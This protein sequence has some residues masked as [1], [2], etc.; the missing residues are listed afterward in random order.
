MKKNYRELVSKEKAILDRLFENPFPGRDE[1]VKQIKL[2]K[3]RSID[4]YKDNYG[5]IEFRLQ[6]DI[7]APVLQRVPVKALA[8]DV[9]NVPIEILLHV[10][11]GK[12]N[13]LEVVKSDGSPI[14]V[15][16]SAEKF[17]VKVRK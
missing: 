9:D 10:V 16:P 15:F 17:E 13:E 3:V 8:Y 7:K 6:V 14:K 4:E 2:S 11:D 12:V 5:S 1:I